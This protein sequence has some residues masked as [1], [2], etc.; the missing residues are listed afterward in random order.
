MYEEMYGPHEKFSMFFTPRRC[1]WNG[2]RDLEGFEFINCDMFCS[3]WNVMKRVLENRPEIVEFAQKWRKEIT[4][5]DLLAF[6]EWEGHK[7]NIRIY[8]LVLSAIAIALAPFYKDDPLAKEYIDM[9][10]NSHSLPKF[11]ASNLTTPESVL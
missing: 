8:R 9:L 1:K 10:A 5:E 3:T 4:P 2:E 11:V 6:I 7:E